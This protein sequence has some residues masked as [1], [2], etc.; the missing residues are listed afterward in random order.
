MCHHP[1][2]RATAFAVGV[3]LVV[4]PATLASTGPS[5][6]D[7]RAPSL[8]PTNGG[9]KSISTAVDAERTA[10]SQLAVQRVRIVAPPFADKERSALVQFDVSNDSPVTVRDIVV[11]ISILAREEPDGPKKPRVLAGP[12]YLKGSFLLE[13]GHVTDYEIGLRNL[14]PACSCRASAGVISARIVEQP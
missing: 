14:S 5:N 11:E 7:G 1:S 2:T 4:L 3:F 9:G 13:P 6:Q 8:Q 12:F 10:L